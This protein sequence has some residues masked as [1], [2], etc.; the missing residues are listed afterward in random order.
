MNWSEFHPSYTDIWRGSYRDIFVMRDLLILFFVKRKF[1]KSFFVIR[2]LKVLRDPRRT[3]IIR[4]LTTPLLVVWDTNPKNGESSIRSD[5]GRQF[6]TR[7]SGVWFLSEN[8]ILFF[9]PR[10]CNVA[11]CTFYLVSIVGSLGLRE[12]VRFVVDW[13]VQRMR[14][15]KECGTFI[16][17]WREQDQSRYDMFIKSHLHISHR[18]ANAA[19]VTTRTVSFVD[20]V[21]SVSVSVLNIEKASFWFVLFTV[22]K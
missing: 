8:Q 6:A 13:A 3:W 19:A 16:R 5:L 21:W 1:R 2:D 14:Q 7:S 17:I 15:I 4:D 12:S 20:Y 10:S 9:V 22:G 18:L 11:Q